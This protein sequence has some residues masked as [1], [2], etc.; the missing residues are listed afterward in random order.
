MVPIKIVNKL[1]KYKDI[2]II[3]DAMI[4]LGEA[5]V[6][7]IIEEETGIVSMWWYYLTIGIGTIINLVFAK[8]YNHRVRKQL[9]N[10]IQEENDELAT[11]LV[12]REIVN[13][14]KIK[15]I[16]ESIV[17]LDDEDDE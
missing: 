12:E 10:L 9:R 8:L 2:N 17:C 4:L 1:L 15:P 3:L 6:A 14:S 16:L 5:G 7:H 13:P 11:M